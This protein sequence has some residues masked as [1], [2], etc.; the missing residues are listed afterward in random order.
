MDEIEIARNLR[1]LRVLIDH[2][3]EPDNVYAHVNIKNA[4]LV[5]ASVLEALDERITELQVEDDC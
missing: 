4:L 3:N 2:T 1:N 5:V